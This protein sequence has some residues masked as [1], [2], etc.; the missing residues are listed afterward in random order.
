VSHDVRIVRLYDAPPE[1]VFRAWV[2]PVART[3][4]YAHHPDDI[5]EAETDLRVGGEWSVRFGRPGARYGEHGVFLEI[6]APHHVVYTMTFTY[7]DGRTFDT[8]TTVE[9][10]DH[11]GK[12]ELTLLDAGYPDEETRRGNEQGWPGFLDKVAEVLAASS[13]M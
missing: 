1:A 13:P 4:W 12:T 10:A 3:T 9:F 5:V 2:D 6:A 8:T 7:P 11:D